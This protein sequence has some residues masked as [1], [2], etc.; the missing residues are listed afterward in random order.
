M[1][2]KIKIEQL[3]KLRKN[4]ND[5]EWDSGAGWVRLN[6]AASSE[7]QNYL[8]DASAHT[9][10]NVAA[11][12]KY[13]E[14][15]NIKPVS[16][17]GG[18]TEIGWERNVNNAISGE[19]DFFLTKSQEN[20]QGH[21]VSYDF[22]IERRHNARILQI[23]VDY[24]VHS[25]SYQTGD[26]T[27]Y[28]IDTTSNEV[29][30]PSSIQFENL[31]SKLTG[32]FLATF[33]THIEN[34]DYRL[35]FHVATDKIESWA[36]QLNNI[37]IWEPQKSVGALITDWQDYIPTTE[38]LGDIQN[39]SCRYRRAGNVLEIAGVFTIGTSNA[40][41]AKVFFPHG[42]KAK[43][44]LGGTGSGDKE[45]HTIGY[46]VRDIANP[47]SSINLHCRNGYG[48]F[49]LGFKGLDT[50][51]PFAGVNGNSMFNPGEDFSFKLSVPIQ[52]WG[53][54]VT[55]VQ[56]DS[57][58]PAIFDIRSDS[59]ISFTGLNYA[60]IALSGI[61]VDSHSGWDSNS[62]EY[63]IPKTGTY[64]LSWRAL[65]TV[66]NAQYWF[67]YITVNS[68]HS[69]VNDTQYAYCFVPSYASVEVSS[70]NNNVLHLKAG[71]RVG[72]VLSPN[73]SYPFNTYSARPEATGLSVVELSA[74]T[75]NITVNETVACRYFNPE[76]HIDDLSQRQLIPDEGFHT[77]LFEQ[78]DYDT[79]SAYDKTTGIWVCPEAGLYKILAWVQF[80]DGPVGGHKRAN[81]YKNGSYVSSGSYAPIS[82]SPSS[83]PKVCTED[84]IQC[85]A[86]DT[87]E[88]KIHQSNIGTAQRITN[89]GNDTV[90]TIYRI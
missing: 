54:T 76:I 33:Q 46:G 2:S 79:H 51:N 82:G 34:L 52:G 56:G 17:E 59:Q 4:H 81:I 63:I 50:N 12:Q 83:R 43:L 71:D 48:Y 14:A 11:W 16:G 30:E 78:K 38:G 23:S 31:D 39:V 53:S 55:T 67:G 80:A 47:A 13:E 61:N 18:S 73:G 3:E 25:G 15:G 57:Q 28:I 32:R 21:G 65:A 40:L 60:P 58:R 24:K 62:N 66:A 89:Y 7:E 86:G 9:T 85:I 22:Q 42:L 72:F 69:G 41:T 88:I 1:S 29:L 90:L 64:Q 49:M 87:I 44:G 35:C 70:G 20:R 75:N 10:A 68:T 74:L 84:V 26:L 45:A 19:A 27:C 8:Q 77:V 6:G 5:L 37:R 36:L